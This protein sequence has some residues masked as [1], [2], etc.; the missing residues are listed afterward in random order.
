MSKCHTKDGKSKCK[1]STGTEE[2]KDYI[3]A[4]VIAALNEHDPKT[5]WATVVT[6]HRERMLR[7]G[8]SLC[9]MLNIKG[10]VAQFTK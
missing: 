10:D 7:G 1:V 9:S 3:T 2:D 6:Q 4:P 8:S 5:K